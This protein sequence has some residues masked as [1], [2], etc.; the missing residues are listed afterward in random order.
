M[1]TT[2]VD[3]ETL[4]ILLESWADIEPLITAVQRRTDLSRTEAMILYAASVLAPDAED[5]REDW[6]TA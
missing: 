2:T 5:D 6:Q 3:T 1:A 4:D